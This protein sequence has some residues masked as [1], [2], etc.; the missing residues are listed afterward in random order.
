MVLR[1]GRSDADILGTGHGVA[2]GRIGFERRAKQIEKQKQQELKE[3]RTSK[4][5]SGGIFSGTKKSISLAIETFPQ[6]RK[7][8]TLKTLGEGKGKFRAFEKAKIKRKKPI[9]SLF[10]K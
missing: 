6:P 5:F 4:H 2:K 3:R 8:R 7:S 10:K 1:R 9:S